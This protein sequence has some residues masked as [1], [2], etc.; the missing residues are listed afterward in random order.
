MESLRE[1]L[2]RGEDLDWLEPFPRGR[3]VAPFER[4]AF[5]LANEEISDVVESVYGFHL[6]QGLR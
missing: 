1:R 2:P 3:M 5:S 6:I 4:V